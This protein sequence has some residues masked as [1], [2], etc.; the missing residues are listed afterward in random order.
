[1]FTWIIHLLG[2]F[3]VD[4]V[5][6]E[7]LKKLY[8]TISEDDILRMDDKGNWFFEGKMLP[9]AVKKQVIAEANVFLDTKLWQILQN[10]VKYQANKRM[11]LEST[12]IEHLE[13]GKAWTYVLDI[14]KTRLE[15]MREGKNIFKK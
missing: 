10:D 3:T 12:K 5:K 4:E 15:M 13:Q 8:N 9:D 14:F 2:G 11:Y 6:R 7:L 1:M